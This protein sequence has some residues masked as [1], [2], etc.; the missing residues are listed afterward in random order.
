MKNTVILLAL[1]LSINAVFASIPKHVVFTYMGNPSTSITVNW[2]TILQGDLAMPVKEAIVY[3]DT[4]SRPAV[5][6]EYTQYVNARTFQ[7]EGLPNRYIHRGQL[8]GLKPDK[9]YYIRV[10]SSSGTLSKEF[11]VHTIPND[12]S[13]I[14]FVTGGDMGTSEETRLLLEHAASYSPNFAAIG[15]DIAYANGQLKSI[16]NWDKW[17]DYYSNEMVTPDGYSIPA[18][19]SIGNHEVRGGYA[20]SKTEAPFYFNF[21]GQDD[22]QS[23][24][25]RK[26]G[27]NLVLFSLDSGHIASHQSQV[28]WLRQELE[29]NKNIRYRAALYHVPLYPS[30]RD[31]MGQ[32][33][34]EGRKHWAPVFDAFALT[35]AFENHDHTYKR[36]HL[37][38]A[39]EAT[40]DGSGTLYLGDGCWGRNAR[41][42]DYD[43][44]PYLHASGSIQHFWYVEMD[45]NSAV[46]RAIDIENQVFDVY[47]SEHPEAEVARA[48]FEEKINRYII[49]QGVVTMSS[50][51]DISA[52]W[53]GGRSEIRIENTF[54]TAIDAKISARYPADRFMV[55]GILSDELHLRSGSVH[56]LGLSIAPI[57]DTP[58]DFE[59]LRIRVDIELFRPAS[60]HQPA[61]SFNKTLLVPYSIKNY[62]NE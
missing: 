10:R 27:A 9:T 17:L 8:Q 5:A 33:S 47:P 1:S 43:P 32:Y 56:T 26:F 52:D 21:F 20:K 51:G 54:E 25:A 48:V 37:L 61:A 46:Y 41:G 44:R 3:Y 13:P 34:A 12:D 11:K 14:S 39:G 19:L 36:T 2:Q 28:D 18:V 55:T 40:G 7:I 60:E 16:G 49:P 42:T 59:Q 30:H 53:L 35:V 57:G 45:T 4:N 15:G 62:A 50:L 24:F 6:D 29:L 38:K 31:P 23:Y 22:A 58:I